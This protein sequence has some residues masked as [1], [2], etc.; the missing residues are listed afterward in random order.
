MSLPLLV[1][2]RSYNRSSSSHKRIQP[3]RV[4]LIGYKTKIWFKRIKSVETEFGLDLI[5]LETV[6]QT[7]DRVID[8]Q[9]TAKDNHA[10]SV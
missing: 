3:I 1:I 4:R 9:R 10:T 5:N 6:R 8:S 2:F 7:R